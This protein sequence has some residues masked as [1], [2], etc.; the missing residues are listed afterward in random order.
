MLKCWL[1]LAIMNLTLAGNIIFVSPSGGSHMFFL[2]EIA[3][4][5]AAEHNVTLVALVP[6]DRVALDPKI[7]IIVPQGHSLTTEQFNKDARDFIGNTIVDSKDSTRMHIDLFTGDGANKQIAAERL[8]KFRMDFFGSDEYFNLIKSGGFDAFVIEDPMFIEAAMPI[9]EFG[10]PF[11]TFSPV[12]DHFT[13]RKRQNY[14]YLYNSEPSY[15]MP[16]P[17]ESAPSFKQRVAAIGDIFSFINTVYPYFSLVGEKLTK[18]GLQTMDDLNHQ[19][20][21]SLINDHPAL[22]FPHLDPLNAINV[23]CFYC[24]P[25]KPLPND[26]TQFTDSSDSPIIYVSF[27]SYAASENV[28]WFEEFITQLED[29]D[30]KVILKGVEGDKSGLAALSDKFL[31]KSW[32]SQKDLLGSG[33]VKVFISHCGNNGRLESVFYKVPILC[34]PLYGDQYMN[35]KLIQKRKFGRMVLKEEMFGETG[36]LVEAL[37]DM[38]DNH[39]LYKENTEIASDILQSAPASGSDKILYYFRLLVKNGNLDFMKN[40]VILGQNMIEMHNLDILF[41]MM[42]MTLGII[43]FILL[44]FIKC[45]CVVKRK[46]HSCIGKAKSD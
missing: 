38:L 44:I 12:L 46:V 14:P 23:G 7:T 19:V 22:S 29:L 33:K 27:G 26:I 34:V 45:C 35:A 37:S 20:H 21:L 30:V 6:V 2:A 8:F 40:D 39:S 32:I 15:L 5:L 28:P 13:P 1:F 43:L 4:V 17:V 36:G 24:R 3:N 11:V 10:I 41:V 18:Y 9:K 16:A 42:A 31:V 25:A